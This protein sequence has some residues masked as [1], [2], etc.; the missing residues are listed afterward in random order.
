MENNNTS[1]QNQKSVLVITES[2]DIN[3]SSGTKGR[4]ALI[5]NLQKIGCEVKVLHY[6][7]RNI[8][9][10][11]INCVSIKENK[12]LLYIFSRIRRVFNRYFKFDAFK[13]S[14]YILGF[15]FEFFNDS[16]SITKGI[17]KYGNKYDLI[18]TLSK[19]VSLRTH[20]AMLKCSQFNSKW[21]VYVHDPYPFSKFPPPYTYSQPGFKA[22]ER[23]FNRVVQ[24]AKYSIFPSQLLKEWMGQ[25]YPNILKTGIIIPH[26]NLELTHNEHVTLPSF[27]D[28]NKF[29]MLHAGNM[30]KQRPPLGLIEGYKLFLNNNPS[31]NSDSKLIHIGNCKDFEA[32]LNAYEQKIDSLLVIKSNMPFDIVNEIQKSCS[33]NVILE[34]NSG[35]SPFLPGK[36][37]H[38]VFANKPIL[39]IGPEKSEVMRLLGEAYPYHATINDSEKIAK[40]IEDLY[41]LWKKHGK[42]LSLDRPDLLEY[43]G[44]KHFETQV[45]HLFNNS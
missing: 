39:A 33:V 32:E 41:L 1:F 23:F 5:K 27:I 29:T 36:F 40:V 19:G 35:I 28:T 9:L 34:S 45:Q 25:F 24:N 4:V 14:E 13:W 43:L 37:P 30:M 10:E 21:A 11:G 22:K 8:D 17:N 44:L 2:I 18:L 7:R 20:H 38:C 42:S 26:Q 16:K 12:F 31:A 3:D 6:T 15:S